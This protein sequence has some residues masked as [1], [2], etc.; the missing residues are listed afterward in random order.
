MVGATTST[1][2]QEWAK[3]LWLLSCSADCCNGS[4][5]SGGAAG[6]AS[7]RAEELSLPNGWPCA[8]RTRSWPISNLC[9]S[10][11]KFILLLCHHLQYHTLTQPSSSRASLGDLQPL[12]LSHI[13]ILGFYL[14]PIYWLWLLFWLA[15]LRFFRLLAGW[16][17]SIQLEAHLS[18]S[19]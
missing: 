6:I 14:E 3:L 10:C 17:V 5:G 13:E 8:W 11:D 9:G 15:L 16:L 4:G 1:R 18:Q 2:S 7:G 19:S 12:E